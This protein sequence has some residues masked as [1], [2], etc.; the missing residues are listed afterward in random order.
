M[1]KV[2]FLGLGVMGYPMAGHLQAAGHEVTVYN[3]TTAKAEA[4]SAAHGGRFA[5]TPREAAEGTEFVMSCVGNDDDLRSVCVGEDGAFA[6]MSAGAVFVDHTT[7]SAKVTRE[8]FDIA[9]EKGIGF[10]DAPISGGQAGAENG[11]L[12]VMCGGEEDVYGK[13]EPVIGAYA[14]ICRRIGDSGAGQMTKMCNQIAIAGLVQGL[15][16]ALH[17]AEKAGLDG[18][19]VVEVISQGA[20]G[21]WQ[22]ANRS[23]TM[24]DD[25]FDHGFAVDWM[26]KDL[27]ICLD[28]ADETGASLPV[29]ALVD[30]FY[31]DVQKIGGGRWD[32]SSLIKRL[33]ALD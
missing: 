29:T 24:L 15:S 33:R 10:V 19:A 18:R 21:S 22:M 32:T 28:T 7:V 2:A 12:S 13:A 9:A 23:D 11:V 3:R 20:A 30:Q 26:R 31:K 16:E 17:F 5:R 27:G 6:G 8:L 1:A 14:R 25:H 4:W